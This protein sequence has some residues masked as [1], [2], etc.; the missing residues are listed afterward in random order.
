MGIAAITVNQIIM[1][2]VIAVVGFAAAKVKLIEEA[3]SRI[4][5]DILLLLVTPMMIFTSYQIE[6]DSQRLKGLLAAVL[7]AFVSHLFSIIVSTV[8]FPKKRK[9]YEVERLAAIF[10]N[11][12]YM[13]I[14]LV[15]GVFGAEGV[16]YVTAYITVFNVLIWT[17]GVVI[18]TGE[19]DIHSCVAALKSPAIISI[20]LGVSCYLLRLRLPEVIL[21]PLKTVSD[22]NTPLAML[23]AGAAI[24]NSNFFSMLKKKQIYQVC[25]VRLILIPAV[26]VFVLKAL[27]TALH[28]DEVVFMTIIMASACP[29]ASN[30]TLFALRYDKD[31]VYASELFSMATVLCLVTIP[32]I[33]LLASI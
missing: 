21:A 29:S 18:M 20:V 17:Y 14:P 4:L 13:G 22:M 12:G 8:L 23:V 28:A 31:F 25:F 15:N 11:C 7:L 9:N 5:S 27:G 1:M 33:M 10:S 26:M 19:C 3:G 6:Y 2:F 32:G 24:A 16:F 30:A